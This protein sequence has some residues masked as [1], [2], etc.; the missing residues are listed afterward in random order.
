MNEVDPLNKLREE[1]NKVDAEIIA[2]LEKRAAI[3]KR[4]GLYKKNKGLPIRDWSR[5]QYILNR[6]SNLKL[7]LIHPDDLVKIY[8]EIMGSCRHLENLQERIGYLGPEGTFCE[9]AARN[10]FSE[11]GNIYVPF[12]SKWQLFRALE[13]DNIDYGVTPVENST[14]GTVTE[15]LD[16]LLDS[17]TIKICGEVEIK[18]HHNLIVHPDATEDDIKLICSHPQAIAQTRE[19]IRENFPNVGIKETLSTASAVKFVKNADKTHAAIG[20]ELAAKKYGLKILRKSI[21]D[22]P[23]NQTRFIIISK[24]SMRPT[25]DDKTSIIFTVRHTPGSLFRALKAFS[26]NNINLTKIESRPAKHLPEIW[27]YNFYTDFEGHIE[28]DNVKNALEILRENS[29]FLK[30]LGSYPKFKRK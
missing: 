21:E 20:T 22:N 5:E 13:A 15:T 8:K 19:Y 10:F 17:S 23:N 28:N 27:Q 12:D 16:L 14:Q 9:I 4:I 29:I 1:I 3:A 7:E 24:Q 26:D 11:A 2:L 6:I 18:I 30:V 25:G